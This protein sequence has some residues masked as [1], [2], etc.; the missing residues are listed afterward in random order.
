MEDVYTNVRGLT[1]PLEQQ[2]CNLSTSHSE[3]NTELVP[4]KLGHLLR[5]IDRVEPLRPLGLF[6]VD[7]SIVTSMVRCCH[8][9]ILSYQR[10]SNPRLVIEVGETLTLQAGVAKNV[11]SPPLGTLKWG[12]G[13]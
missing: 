13:L 3:A 6:S 1:V 4:G 8:C 11:K 5:K 10:F 9:L 7:R 2:L 12:G